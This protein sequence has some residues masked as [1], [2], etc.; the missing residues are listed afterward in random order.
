MTAELAN[1]FSSA[2]HKVTENNR[3]MDSNSSRTTT[4]EKWKWLN[5]SKLVWYTAYAIWRVTKLQVKT[6]YCQLSTNQASLAIQRQWNTLKESRVKQNQNTMGSCS[7]GYVTKQRQC[8]VYCWHWKYVS[9]SWGLVLIL[10]MCN[11]YFQCI[12][13]MSTSISWNMSIMKNTMNNK[14]WY[15]RQKG[16]LLPSHSPPNSRPLQV[17]YGLCVLKISVSLSSHLAAEILFCDQFVLVELEPGLGFLY[18]W[19]P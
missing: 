8:H 14:P 17:S 18:D 19:W 9:P 7:N 6:S 2:Y 5:I 16:R 3:D 1:K 11:V 12:F 13:P 15:L 4:K 10:Q